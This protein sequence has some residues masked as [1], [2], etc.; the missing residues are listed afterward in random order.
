VHPAVDDRTRLAYVG[1]HT[2]ERAIIC[3]GFLRWTAAFLAR[4]GVAI[5]P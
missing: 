4:H 5:E 2:N 3:A 1:V